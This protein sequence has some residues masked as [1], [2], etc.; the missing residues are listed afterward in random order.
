[1]DR[2]F[3]GTCKK[4]QIVIEEH[5]R[6]DWFVWLC[7]LG[8]KEC[9]FIA[10][11]KKKKKSNKQNKYYRGVVVPI[12]AGMMGETDDRAHGYLQLEHFVYEDDAGRKYIRSTRLKDWD[13]IEWENKMSEIRQWASEIFPGCYIPLPN[14][15][16][17]Y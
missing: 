15:V 16:D 2:V 14:E 10:R 8:D 7:T 4:G 3:P 11:K 9:E 5:D 12:I 13:T 6:R 17:N 1:M